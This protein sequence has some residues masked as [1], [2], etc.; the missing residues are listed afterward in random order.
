MHDA[1]YVFCP[2]HISSVLHVVLTQ[3][4]VISDIVQ[5]WLLYN[6]K[7]I[8]AQYFH[9]LFTNILTVNLG[10]SII[11]ARIELEFESRD[12]QIERCSSSDLAGPLCL[13]P[14]SDVMVK[15]TPEETL[16]PAS[17]QPSGKN[18]G[19]Y[20]WRRRI[21][22]RAAQCCI[23]NPHS[24]CLCWNLV[25][26]ARDNSWTIFVRYD[27][28]WKLL[29]LKIFLT[30]QYYHL[31]FKQYRRVIRLT[32]TVVMSTNPELYIQGME[33]GEERVIMSI[34]WMRCS[35]EFKEAI[36]TCS[37]AWECLTARRSFFLPCDAAFA[38]VP[39]FWLTAIVR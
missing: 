3:F 33:G 10:S 9:C 8:E 4:S 15:P 38:H 28:M 25:L 29:S 2:S 31:R 21:A 11:E 35:D 26:H 24:S 37:Y 23:T 39:H 20:S 27:E 13:L 7:F 17:L 6:E 18:C 19:W 14:A 12:E 34:W 36:C 32:G 1:Y 30:I 16:P 5:T 22:K